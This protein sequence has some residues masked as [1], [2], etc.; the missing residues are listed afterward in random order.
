VK[1]PKAATHGNIHFHDIG[2]YLSREDKLAIIA[3]FGSI[4]GITKANG[5]QAITPTSTAIG[6][7]SATAR[8][9]RSCPLGIKT[10]RQRRH[11]SRILPA[12]KQIV[13]LGVLIQIKNIYHKT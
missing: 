13:M 11:S 3:R 12:Y 4:D 9:K 7:G 10:I 2:D 8:L 6:W 1:N 5:W